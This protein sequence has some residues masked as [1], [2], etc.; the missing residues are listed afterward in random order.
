MHL[1]D[2]ERNS[3]HNP[4]RRG[5]GVP[6]SKVPCTFEK[7]VHGSIEHRPI[8]TTCTNR[9]SIVLESF[10]KVNFEYTAWRDLL[11]CIFL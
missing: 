4:K 8:S 6:L 10:L 7:N 9:Q 11:S 3:M 1:S 2:L 5:K